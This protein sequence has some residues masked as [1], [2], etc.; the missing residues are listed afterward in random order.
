MIFSAVSYTLGEVP[1]AFKTT[2]G[3]YLFFTWDSPPC[4]QRRICA[5]LVA[6][7]W[8]KGPGSIVSRLTHHRGPSEGAYH[9]VVLLSLVLEMESKA[10][11][12]AWPVSSTS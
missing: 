9:C 3:S 11:L 1:K 2:C 12:L 10:R 8:E 5:F 7:L 4:P 6:L